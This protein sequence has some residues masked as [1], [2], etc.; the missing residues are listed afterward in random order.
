M[1]NKYNIPPP[2][3]QTINKNVENNKYMT[4]TG[5]PYLHTNIIAANIL[6]INK[7]IWK[8]RAENKYNFSYNV[9]KKN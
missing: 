6:Y 9:F 1:N 5:S 3:I 8:K 2:T 7:S 4:Y